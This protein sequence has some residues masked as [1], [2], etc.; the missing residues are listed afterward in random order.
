MHVLVAWKQNLI[1]SASKIKT[2]LY[3]TFFSPWKH[4]LRPAKTGFLF[5]SF[6]QIA[7]NNQIKNNFISAVVATL[8]ALVSLKYPNGVAPRDSLISYSPIV[9]SRVQILCCVASKN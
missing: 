5:E 8:L 2:Q 7:H 3:R 4:E 6:T 1:F 9:S